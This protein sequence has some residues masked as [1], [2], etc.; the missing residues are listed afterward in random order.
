MR[1][2][3]A[4]EDLKRALNLMQILLW[5]EFLKEVRLRSQSDSNSEL[6]GHCNLLQWKQG[7]QERTHYDM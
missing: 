5:S 3:N 7:T 1:N 6:H 2:T 4:A